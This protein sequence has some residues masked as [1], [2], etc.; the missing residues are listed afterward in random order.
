MSMSDMVDVVGSRERGPVEDV[1]EYIRSIRGVRTSKRP[2]RLALPRPFSRLPSF[3]DEP[4]WSL[5]FDT[6]SVICRSWIQVRTCL[7]LRTP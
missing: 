4:P 3:H 2:R 5:L 1:I 7:W 6:L